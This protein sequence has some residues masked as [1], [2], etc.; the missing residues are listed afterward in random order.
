MLVQCMN[1]GAREW[2]R[3]A[4][5]IS[6]AVFSMG[7]IGWSFDEQNPFLVTMAKGITLDLREHGAADVSKLAKLGAD[8]WLWS[9]ASAKHEAYKG[10]CVAPFLAP[11]KRLMYKKALNETWTV[12]HQGILAAIAADVLWYNFGCHMCG[13]KGGP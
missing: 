10:F 11:L 12:G 4:G 3:S 8:D 9:K 13:D 6:A 2:R 7:R 5:P 1:E